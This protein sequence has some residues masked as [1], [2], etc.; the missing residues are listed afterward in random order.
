VSRPRAAIRGRV[1]LPMV[2]V[3][4]V[5][6]VGQAV[7]PQQTGTVDLLSQSSFRIDGATAFDAA[8]AAV[9]GAGDVNGDGIDDLVIGAPERDFEAG[10]AYVVFGRRAP[11]NVDLGGLRGDGFRINGAAA[12]DSAGRSVGG[13]GDVNG[14]GLADVIIGAELADNNGRSNSGSAYVVFGRRDVANLDLGALGPG[15]FRIDGA[16]AGDDA[17]ASVAGAGDLNADGLADLL[18]GA[19]GADPN[20]EASGSAYVIFGRRITTTVD[21]AALGSEGF[22]M[23]GAQGGDFAGSAVAAAG[24]VSGDGRADVVVGAIGADNN[25]RS[26]SGSAYVVFGQEVAADIQ[27][28]ALGRGGFRIDGAAFGDGAGNSIAPGGDLNADGRADLLVGASRTDNNGRLESGSAYVVFGQQAPTNVDLSTLGGSGFRIDGAALGD[29]AGTAVAAPGDLDGD[30]RTDVL[31]G[32]SGADNNGRLDSGSIYAVG[33]GATPSDVDLATSTRTLRIDGATVEDNVG[34]AAG[35]G[36]VNGDGRSDIVVGSGNTD[37][38]DLVNSGSA[39][40]IY[41]AGAPELAYPA[42]DA[43][44]GSPVSIVPTTLRRTGP[45]SFSVSPTLP[46]G[47]TLNAS[48]GEITGRPTVPAPRSTFAVTMTDLAGSVSAPLSVQVAVP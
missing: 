23:D 44:A 26:G 15:G 1:L 12:E 39:Y 2:I 18:V 4:T 27:L 48:T 9:D 17:G 41:G 20:G 10:A 43:T 35:A 3:L 33:V 8:G 40:V 6:T 46:A 28:S 25:A 21:L 22:R 47:L 11:A 38:N 13:A 30:G 24:D 45:A 29:F 19:N 37:N 7:L 31:L 5:A 36:D 34:A 32:A 42:V 16:A 14:D